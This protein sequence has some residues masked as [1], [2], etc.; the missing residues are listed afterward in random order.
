MG[1]P[2]LLGGPFCYGM[3]A[4]IPE[5]ISPWRNVPLAGWDKVLYNRHVTMY[6][7]ERGEPL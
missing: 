1:L 3:P 4:G 7:A 5:R 6:C 2:G